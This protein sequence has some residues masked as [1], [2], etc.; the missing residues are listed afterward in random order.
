MNQFLQ[1]NLVTIIIFLLLLIFLLLGIMVLILFKIV[2]KEKHADAQ[3]ETTP[4]VRKK[5]YL[6]TP[7]VEKNYCLHHTT[8]PSCGSCL[9]CEEVFCKDCLVDHDGLHFCKEHFRIFASSKWKQITDEKTTPDTPTESLYIYNFKHDLWSLKNV[10]TF[11]MTHY[12]INIENDYIESF[13]Q[14]NVRAEDA[15]H[16]SL[17]IL[18]YKG[19]KDSTG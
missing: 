19:L 1:N 10:P 12:K 13:V 4:V 17:E 15:E 18:K 2:T 6:E 5:G 7:V 9:I 3:S 14:L 11:I 16:L 8:A